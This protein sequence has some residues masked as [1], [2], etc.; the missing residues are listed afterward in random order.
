MDDN[1]VDHFIAVSYLYFL[2]T[3]KNST[4]VSRE[5]LEELIIAFYET[6]EVGG[7]IDSY[8]V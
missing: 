4:N 6:N 5:E 3:N 8:L 2:I 7:Q 1:H